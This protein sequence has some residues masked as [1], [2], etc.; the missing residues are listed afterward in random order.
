[1]KSIRSDFFVGRERETHT[2]RETERERDRERE[3]ERQRERE[4]ERE[5]TKETNKYFGILFAEHAEKQRT[6]KQHR[7]RTGEV[8]EK[9]KDE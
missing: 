9:K 2:Q 6:D 7:Y 5:K 8:K 4:R 1:M 3:T